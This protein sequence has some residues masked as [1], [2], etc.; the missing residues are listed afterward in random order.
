MARKDRSFAAKLA[1]AGQK[2]ILVCPVCN[3][4]MTAHRVVRGIVNERTGKWRFRERSVKI[5]ACN[6]A[7]FG[8]G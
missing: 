2:E 7:E 4:D 6:K 5:C 1:H 8:L 3:Q